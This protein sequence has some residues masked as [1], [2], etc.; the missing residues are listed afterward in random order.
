MI[1]KDPLDATNALESHDG[2][3]KA[4]NPISVFQR[5]R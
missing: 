5:L 3:R 2:Y 1:G 4:V